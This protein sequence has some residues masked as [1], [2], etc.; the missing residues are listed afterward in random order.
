M[1]LDGGR[2][3]LLDLGREGERGEL[4]DVGGEGE[5]FSR[6]DVE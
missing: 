2:G 3:E 1:D 5:R 6:G 4:L